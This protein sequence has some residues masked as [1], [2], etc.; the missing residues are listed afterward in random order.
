M[1]ARTVTAALFSILLASTAHA[2]SG[3]IKSVKLSSGGVAE[4]V[5]AAAVDKSG[6]VEIEV[7]LSQVDDLLKS[8]VVFSD[9]A[10]VR[11]LSLAGP[12]PVEETFERLPFSPSDMDS[13]STVRPGSSIRSS[14]SSRGKSPLRLSCFLRPA[15]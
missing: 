9:K 1:I 11:D 14:A 10:A 3:P 4:I 15:I 12:Q 8:L 6:T 5:R 2:G 7:P 13:S